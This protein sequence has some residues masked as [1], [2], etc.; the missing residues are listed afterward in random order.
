MTKLITNGADALAGRA[1]RR[2][3]LGRSSAVLLGLVG[4]AVVAAPAKAD[5]VTCY[6]CG[7]SPRLKKFT[8]CAHCKPPTGCT[9][10]TCIETPC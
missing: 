4:A 1:S 2:S 6:N 9:G 5:T 8:G 7:C 3:F 10:V